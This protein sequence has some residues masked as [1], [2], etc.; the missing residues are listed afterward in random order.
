MSSG[1]RKKTPSADSHGFL[2]L[3]HSFILSLLSAHARSSRF[4]LQNCLNF[5]T[6]SWVPVFH[7]IRCRYLNYM[8]SE[9]LAKYPSAFPLFST[10]RTL[11]HQERQVLRKEKKRHGALLSSIYHG[12]LLRSINTNLPS[13]RLSSR[14]VLQSRDQTE[15][16]RN[17][18]GVNRCPRRCDTSKGH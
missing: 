1:L 17:R 3:F 13:S 9:E 12:P 11:S 7:F 4:L 10:F 16:R 6:V 2:S 15:C 14:L 18:V 8:S 5:Q